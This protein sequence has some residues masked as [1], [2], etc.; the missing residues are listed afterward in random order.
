MYFICLKLPVTYAL[1]RKQYRYRIYSTWNARLD[2]LSEIRADSYQAIYLVLRYGIN[3]Y[4]KSVPWRLDLG[5]G[6]KK[7]GES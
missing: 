4:I 1:P 2:R 7:K 6:T 5:V 3:L